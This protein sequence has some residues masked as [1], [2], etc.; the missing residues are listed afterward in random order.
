MR[1]KR[2]LAVAMASALTAAGGVASVALSAG[3]AAAAGITTSVA[4]P[5]TSY[6][7]MLVDPV[8]HHLF[9]TA[10]TGSSSIWVTDYSG[11]M[12]ATI[13]NEPGGIAGG[14]PGRR[15]A[16]DH[17]TPAGQLRRVHRDRCRPHAREVHR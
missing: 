15:P 1:F 12:V 6:T 14:G 13:D 9:L 3:P 16:G 8:H 4:L 10:G 7:Q 2:A 11:Q 17:S 5:F